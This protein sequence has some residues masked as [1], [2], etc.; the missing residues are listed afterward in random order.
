MIASTPSWSNR[1]KLSGLSAP[2]GRQQP[3][4]MTA[5]VSG[6]D[7]PTNPFDAGPEERKSAILQPGEN[8][9][10]GRPPIL[11]MQPVPTSLLPILTI[12]ETL[13]WWFDS[14]WPKDAI[15]RT[16]FSGAGEC[17]GGPIRDCDATATL[18]PRGEQQIQRKPL[19]QSLLRARSG[20]SGVRGDLTQ[21]L[22]ASIRS[23]FVRRNLV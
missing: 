22:V 10:V 17:S 12:H 1:Q 14:S 18:P 16:G 4:P 7:E 2:L 23:G 19:R 6:I 5:T 8:L 21:L 13:V 3:I 11:I 20:N 15:S 9:R